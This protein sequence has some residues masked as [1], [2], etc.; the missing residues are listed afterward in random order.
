MQLF[1]SKSGLKPKSL[2]RLFNSPS[3]RDMCIVAA[4]ETGKS[5]TVMS[6]GFQVHRSSTLWEISK[7]NGRKTKVTPA[8]A[9]MVAQKAKKESKDHQ[10]HPDESEQ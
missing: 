1:S 3:L 10:D 9:R 8:L 6:K 5:N 4:H 7:G 2:V